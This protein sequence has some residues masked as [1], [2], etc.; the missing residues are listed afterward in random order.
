MKNDSA[1][2]EAIEMYFQQQFQLYRAEKSLTIAPEQ[3]IFL[4]KVNTP[5][6]KIS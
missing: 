6:E 1:S 4:N 3:V 5:F 2:V